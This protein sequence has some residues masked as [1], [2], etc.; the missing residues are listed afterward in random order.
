MPRYLL[1]SFAT[2]TLAGCWMSDHL[3]KTAIKNLDTVIEYKVG[4]TL[5][6]YY[7]QKKQL[8]R[9]TTKFLNKSKSMAPAIQKKLEGYKELIS[10][11]TPTSKMILDEI[12]Y[13]NGLYEEVAEN[14]I[15]EHMSYLSELTEKQQN[16]FFK[17]M[18]KKNKELADK[19][20]NSEEEDLFK[21]YKYIFSELNE[22]QKK[23][24]KKNK[25]HL[26]KR[27]KAYLERRREFQN[28]LKKLWKKDAPQDKFKELALKTVRTRSNPQ[29][30]KE[31]AAIIEDLLKAMD[32]KGKKALLENLEKF[33]AWVE[34]FSST[35]Y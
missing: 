8:E 5:G 10:D 6:L 12:R 19:I 11:K 20:K 3:I 24:L 34:T 33:E 35:R 29:A 15:L 16:E 7:A 27:S 18:E 32:D 22:K 2:V 9:D 17:E 14:I 1:F 13:W 4:D 25:D 30:N 26:E 23:V 28:E 21:S 31:R